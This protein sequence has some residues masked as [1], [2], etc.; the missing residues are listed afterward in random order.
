MIVP[1]RRLAALSAV[2]SLLV[3]PA[4]HAQQAVP[5]A[6]KEPPAAPDLQNGLYADLGLHVLGVGFE[7]VVHPR[8][9][10]QI[11]ADYYQPWTV[12]GN[13]LGAA[14]SNWG[15]DRN[16]WGVGGRARA[17]IFFGFADEDAPRG[18]F[19]S[20]FVQVMHL[21]AGSG[22]GTGTGLGWAVGASAG[23]SLVLADAVALRLGLGVQH[24]AADVRGDS[25]FQG[26]S[27]IF[28][29]VDIQ[30]GYVF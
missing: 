12:N 9:A 20:P 17:F 30:A 4:A 15:A 28:P 22:A 29:Q 5:A 25:R 11:A 21:W 19:V 10:V 16:T 2:A 27:G 13:V 14:G 1:P 3:I 26:F 23:Y 24:H 8:V 18:L 6:P 7:R